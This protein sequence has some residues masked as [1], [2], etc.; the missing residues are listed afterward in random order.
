MTNNFFFCTSSYVCLTVSWL[1]EVGT[2]HDDPAR[3]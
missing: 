2:S 1:I 3:A